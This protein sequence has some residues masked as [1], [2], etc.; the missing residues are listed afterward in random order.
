MGKLLCDSSS[1]GAAVAVAEALLPSPAPPSPPSAAACS[2]SGRSTTSSGWSE[3]LALHCCGPIPSLPVAR[4]ADL[5]DNH[6]DRHDER[7]ALNRLEDARDFAKRALRGVDGALK[8]LGSVQYMLHDLGAGAAG[9]RQAMEEQLQ[10]AARKLQL[11]AVSTC[12]TRSL[13][14]MATEPPIGNRVQ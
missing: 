12:N 10:A 9:G 6:H 4:I 5:R 7:L 1:G 14:R 3:R 8:L 11:V 2:G 13:A